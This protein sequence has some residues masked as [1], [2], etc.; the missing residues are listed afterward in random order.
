MPRDYLPL[1][2]PDLSAFA[3]SLGR[4]LKERSESGPP[5]HVELLNLIAR[6]AGHRNLAALQA[7]SRAPRLRLAVEDRPAPPP[8]SANARK[9]LQQFDSRG[10]LLRWPVK[11]SVQRLA[12][13]VLWTHFDRRRTYTEAEVNAVLKA[14]NAF[15]DHVTLRREL[16]NH[17]LMQR[18]SDGSEYRKCAARPDDEERA[19]LAAWHALR[20]RRTS[21]S[22]PQVAGEEV[23]RLRGHLG[24]QRSA[25][26]ARGV[27]ADRLGCQPAAQRGAGREE[28]VVRGAG[29]DAE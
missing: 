23:Q 1:S 27:A 3:R 4:S 11:F 22:G 26:H 28:N 10:R 24:V 5:G 12:M 7:A 13:W 15:G 20:A 6:A 2:T 9:A 21:D 19:L 14:L 16:I 25:V 18:K 8:L 17:R 29:Q